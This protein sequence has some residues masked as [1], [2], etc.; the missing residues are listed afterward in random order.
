VSEVG[1][2][3]WAEWLLRRRHGDDPER[4]KAI[5]EQLSQVRDA[6]VERARLH[7][8]GTLLDVG[9][10]DGLIGFGALDRVGPTGRVIFADVSQ[11]LLDLCR[12]R[13]EQLDALERCVFV[14][15]SADRLDA[16]AG[17]SVDA[18]TT[19]SVLIYVADKP[20]CFRQFHRVLRP[21][22]R[23]SLS[24][25]VNAFAL[26]ICRDGC[27]WGYDVAPVADLAAKVLALYTDVQP[28]DTDPML[29]FD[30]RDLL[31]AAE[32]AGF[33]EI[34]LELRVDIEPWLPPVS[35]NTFA[36]SSGNPL[37]PTIAEAFAQTLSPAETE[38]FQAHL[39]PLV[40]AGRGEH[41]LAIASLWATKR[42]TE[43]PDRAA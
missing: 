12:Q 42:P 17:D 38:R 28:P 2:D 40:E 32:Q 29:D 36:H 5:L 21:G 6:V 33:T 11:D 43:L 13:A 4:Q 41:R 34:H 3:R 23:L 10:G 26:R 7:A 39:R 15:G 19:R 20:A 9:C 30:E 22:G 8:G 25:P 14:R 24:E 37:I 35:W 16:V 31:H 1:R 18:V 27:F